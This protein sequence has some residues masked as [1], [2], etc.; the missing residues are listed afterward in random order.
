MCTYDKFSKDYKNNYIYMYITK[1]Q[2]WEIVR[3][4]KF[5]LDDPKAERRFKNI[6]H[7]V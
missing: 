2:H 7:L 5:G 1:V 4:E 3:G 6:M